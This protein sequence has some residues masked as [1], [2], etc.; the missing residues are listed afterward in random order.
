MDVVNFLRLIE[1]EKKSNIAVFLFNF[2][3]AIKGVKIRLVKLNGN[4]K[5]FHISSKELSVL[6]CAHKVGPR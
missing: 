3:T 4:V 2:R 5:A 1:Q 6:R